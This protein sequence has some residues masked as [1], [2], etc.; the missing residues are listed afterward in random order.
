M[1]KNRLFILITLWLGKPTTGHLVPY[2]LGSTTIMIDASEMPAM[3]SPLL[4]YIMGGIKQRLDKKPSDNTLHTSS[5]DAAVQRDDINDIEAIAANLVSSDKVEH[6][7]NQIVSQP[8]VSLDF[9][10]NGQGTVTLEAVGEHPTA[11]S[12]SNDGA[13]LDGKDTLRHQ[14]GDLKQNEEHT[15]NELIYIA[16]ESPPDLS[17]LTERPEILTDSLEGYVNKEYSGVP[18]D[19]IVHDL[20]GG[21]NVNLKDVYIQPGPP[22]LNFM[23]ENMK[24]SSA[25]QLQNEKEMMNN[26]LISTLEKDLDVQEKNSNELENASLNLVERDTSSILD[27]NSDFSNFK[28][29]VLDSSPFSAYFGEFDDQ[30]IG[31]DDSFKP[32]PPLK[33][34]ELDL[35]NFPVVEKTS[36][37]NPIGSVLSE[38]SGGNMEGEAYKEDNGNIMTSNEES[39]YPRFEIVPPHGVKLASSEEERLVDDVKQIVDSLTESEPQ[40]SHFVHEAPIENQNDYLAFHNFNQA[41]DFQRQELI[42]SMQLRQQDLKP[43]QQQEQVE[44]EK[45]NSE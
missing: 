21:E 2:T 24:F 29:S 44:S 18:V 16:P 27:G 5:I 26:D 11:A 37:G 42:L 13:D 36:F 12:S 20:N 22:K 19:H 39:K 34:V 3:P 33:V 4:K 23:E 40:L 7:N 9:L 41:E 6:V 15:F 31:G 35:P 14:G 43:H 38:T 1:L 28:Y 17:I 8:A 10:S 45:R 32:G 25:A 30:A